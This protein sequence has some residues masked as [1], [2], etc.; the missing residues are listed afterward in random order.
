MAQEED[1]E[2]QTQKDVEED[3]LAEKAEEVKYNEDNLDLCRY[4][5]QRL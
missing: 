1:S 3:P 4:H 2:T 5:W